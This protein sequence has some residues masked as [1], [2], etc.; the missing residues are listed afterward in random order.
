MIDKGAPLSR[1]TLRQLG[2]SIAMF[3]RSREGGKARLLIALLI[4]L[5]L[6]INGMNV[7][8]SY[9]SR[10]FMSAIQLRDSPGFVK[11]AWL[12]AAG[13]SMATVLAVLFRYT[14]ERLGLLWRDWLTRVVTKLYVDQQVYVRLKSDSS[15]TNPDQR[16]AEDVKSLTVTTLS[17]VL[18]TLN[19]VMTAVAFSGVLWEISPTLFLV[20]VVYA[21]FGSGMTILLGRPLVRLNYMQADFEADFRSELIRLRDNADSIALTGQQGRMRSRLLTRIDRLIRNLM[22]IIAVNR[23]LGFFTTGY[24][25]MIQLLPALIVAPLFIREGVEF[26]VIAQ[27]AIAFSTL[28]AA[29]SLIVTQ[30][31]SISAYATVVARLEEFV[32]A[33]ESNAQHPVGG[34]LTCN[35]V[36]D[37][38]VFNDVTLWAG[39]QTE[40]LLIK[41]L[42]VVFPKGKRVLVHGPN[43]AAKQALFRAVAGLNDSGS[44]CIDRPPPQKTAYLPEQPFLPR[45]TMRE[46]LVS[47]DC[48]QAVTDEELQQVL[49]DVG[50]SPRLIDKVCTETHDNWHEQMN[51]AEEQLL[52]VARVLLA[53]PE[54]VFLEHLDSG[55]TVETESRV[56]QLLAKRGITCISISDREV[57]PRVHDA[58]LELHD[59]ASWRWMVFQ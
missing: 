1:Q 32:K 9:F 58:S 6:A 2:S 30:F 37:R 48:D 4:I 38:F 10:Y 29:F 40:H 16:I 42:N 51:F 3:L 31:Q 50:L 36:E 55:L 5:M 20:A 46:Y 23:N 18:M 22:R 54:F 7:L 59:D 41:K 53:R 28:T 13:F 12:S 56:L 19:S 34:Y 21:L 44:G 27:S 52:A 35:L 49:R 45:G 24:N 33:I 15:L 11:F 8:N 57:D 39:K 17:F 47:P 26:G 43:G 14:E 25:Y